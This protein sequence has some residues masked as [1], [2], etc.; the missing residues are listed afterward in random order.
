MYIILFIVQ[1]LKKCIRMFPGL[2]HVYTIR[3]AAGCNGQQRSGQ[4]DR[5][6]QH[7]FDPTSAWS[8]G[9]NRRGWATGA[10]LLEGQKVGHPHIEPTIRPIWHTSQCRQRVRRVCQLLPQGLLDQY[11]D[12]DFEA[13]WTV[14][15]S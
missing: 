10:L 14:Q 1:Y 7:D 9:A 8:R 4:L 15:V 5:C 6:M 2:F 13:A 12:F 11:T 3:A